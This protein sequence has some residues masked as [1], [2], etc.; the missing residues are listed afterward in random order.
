MASLAI[1][2]RRQY[3]VSLDLSACWLRFALRAGLHG[4]RLPSVDR[5][6]SRHFTKQMSVVPSQNVPL[7]PPKVASDVTLAGTYVGLCDWHGRIVW[8]SGA[9][10]RLQVG[11]ELWKSAASQSKESLKTAVAS[12][13]TLRENCTLQI[14]N[15]WNEHFRVWLWPLDDPQIAVAVLAMRVP[16]E[17]ALLTEREAEC[18]RCLAQGMSTRGISTELDIGL[19]TVHTHLRRSREKLGLATNEALIGLA[20][21]YYSACP[22]SGGDDSAEIGRRSG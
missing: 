20:A 1:R 15:Q 10:V 17:L 7:G 5:F 13:V 3:W 16:S 19:T 6:M 11:E 8:K 9:D 21:R 2:H 22:P 12:V 4:E 18:L 14:E